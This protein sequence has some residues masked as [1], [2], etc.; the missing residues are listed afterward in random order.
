M[1][2]L[3]TPASE[4]AVR[5]DHILTQ[6]FRQCYKASFKSKSLFH[7]K[8][9]PANFNLNTNCRWLL[10]HKLPPRISTNPS[11]RTIDF[12]LHLHKHWVCYVNLLRSLKS[13]FEPI[14]FEVRPCLTSISVSGTQGFNVPKQKQRRW[15]RRC[16]WRCGWCRWCNLWMRIMKMI[17]ILNHD[18]PANPTNPA[19]PA[20]PANSANQPPTNHANSAKSASS[21]TPPTA[22]P[23]TLRASQLCELRYPREI[24]ERRK[25][26]DTGEGTI[27]FTTRAPS[28]GWW[29]SAALCWAKFWITPLGTCVGKNEHERRQ[30]SR[31]SLLAFPKSQCGYR[32]RIAVLGVLSCGAWR[33]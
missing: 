22:K 10:R 23:G 14:W 19:N 2:S 28:A 29:G 31:G 13:K 27:I 5:Q 12:H 15:C 6:G 7:K 20:D 17:I 3:I 24:R 21:P 30:G 25:L 26:R 32:P 9:N 16:W 33:R 11:L 8:H 18:G 1:D 4:I